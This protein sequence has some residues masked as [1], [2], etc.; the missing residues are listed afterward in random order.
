MY[1]DEYRD[2]CLAFPGVTETFP[3]DEKT[4]V[5]KVMNKMFALTDVDSFDF[6]NLRSSEEG[7]IDLRERYSG[8]KPGYHMNK[9]LWNSVYTDGSVDDDMIYQLIRESYDIIVSG[10]TKK[11][12]EELNN[13]A[14]E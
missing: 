3:F 13:L 12:K 9:K 11:L 14:A 7:C 2:F 10:L 6:I 4:L 5:F 1:I 8:I